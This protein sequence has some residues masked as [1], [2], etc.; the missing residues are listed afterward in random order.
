MLLFLEIMA[1]LFMITIM[2]VAI[3]GFINQNQMLAQMKYKN[4]LLEK[5]TQNMH[6]LATKFSEEGPINESSSQ[7]NEEKELVK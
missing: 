7:K 3:W 1:A 5:L 2:F 4:Y 6:M